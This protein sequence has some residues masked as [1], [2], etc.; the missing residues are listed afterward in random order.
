MAHQIK[1]IMTKHLHRVGREA[2]LRDV[3]RMMKDECIGDVLVTESSGKLCGII[4]DR[5]IVVRGIAEG[6]DMDSTSAGDICS[7]D[8][9]RLEPTSTVDQAVQLMRERSVRRVPVVNDGVPVGIVSIGD[10]ARKLDPSSALAEISDA[11]PNN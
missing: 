6:R 4:T 3:A 11:P 10:L 1:D 8:P 5:D 7:A 9:V 2:R